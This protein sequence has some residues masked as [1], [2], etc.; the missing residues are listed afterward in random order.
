MD[1]VIRS[2]EGG[3]I[4]FINEVPQV[5]TTLAKALVIVKAAYTRK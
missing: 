1:V 2:L 4:I 5:V 3:F